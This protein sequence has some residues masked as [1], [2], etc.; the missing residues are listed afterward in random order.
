MKTHV[1]GGE[2][3]I[4]LLPYNPSLNVGGPA[5]FTM[6]QYPSWV[7]E[8]DPVRLTINDW[9]LYDDQLLGAQAVAGLGFRA[10]SA[11]CF[12]LDPMTDEYEEQFVCVGEDGTG[13]GVWAPHMNLLLTADID[14]DGQTEA[15]WYINSHRERGPRLLVCVEMEQLRVEWIL[16][17]ASPIKRFWFHAVSD[18]ANAALWF[19]SYNPKQGVS[20]GS[21]SDLYGYLTA[22]DGQG[23]IRQNAI[24][25]FQHGGM[26]LTKAVGGS[27]FYLT[28]ELLPVVPGDTAALTPSPVYRLSRL[29]RCGTIIRTIELARQPDRVWLEQLPG[30]SDSLLFVGFADR[31]I[32]VFD[33]LFQ[34]V[35][36]SNPC[37]VGVF[38]GR[39][40]LAGES[41]ELLAFSSGLYTLDFDKQLA[42]P[43]AAS[44]LDIVT[45]DS[46][47]GALTV[48]LGGGNRFAIGAVVSKRWW[49]YGGVFVSRNHELIIAV[50]AVLLAAL[51]MAN[52]LRQKAAR[53]MAASQERFNEVLSHSRDIIFGLN[54]ITGS[55]A[56]MSASIE[57]ILGVRCPMSWRAGWRVSNRA[58]I[59]MTSRTWILS[60]VHFCQVTEPCCRSP[61]NSGSG[62]AMAASSGSV[63]PIQW[64]GTPRARSPRSSAWCVISAQRRRRRR[65]F[66]LA[67]HVSASCLIC[68]LRAFMR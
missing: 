35:A 66:G 17:V 30:R 14:A 43:F 5:I 54:A 57:T 61:S 24:I 25:A 15:F 36:E 53:Q 18:S 40:R 11:F 56:Y 16:P 26:T 6:R 68:C 32:R 59:R 21:F 44:R 60:G 65:R 13:D 33:T 37:D 34:Q 20:D 62:I 46:S 52:R 50:L 39:L 1:D 28:H 29:D 31:V 9:G 4:L 2:E 51:L 8:D 45:T 67:K 7:V 23:R 64:C 19:V 12:R 10:D 55:F 3:G 42:F 63:R 49:E 38:L 47:G 58:S 22:V 48:G 41:R 27:G